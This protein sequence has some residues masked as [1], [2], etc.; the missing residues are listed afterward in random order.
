MVKQ[1]P[2]T[3]V[4]TPMNPRKPVYVWDLEGNRVEIFDDKYQCAE[5]LGVSHTEISP[6]VRSGH[7]IG[8]KYRLT[9]TPIRPKQQLA[10]PR[11]N[12][13]TLKN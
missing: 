11:R 7:A 8:S 1:T 13:K 3:C 5:W 2:W 10:R 6:V 9:Y 12:N 4:Q